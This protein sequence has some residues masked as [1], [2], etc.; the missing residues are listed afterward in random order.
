MS[1]LKSGD[2]PY[3][4]GYST[5]KPLALTSYS[6]LKLS[7]LTNMLKDLGLPTSVLPSATTLPA[8]LSILKTRHQQFVTLHNANTDIAP[9]DPLH[10][11]KK[12]LQA[13]LV[14][15]EKLHNAG[16]KT[17]DAGGGVATGGM[18][19]VGGGKQYMVCLG[20]PDHCRR[21]LSTSDPRSVPQKKHKID[22][23][24]LTRQARASMGSKVQRSNGDPPA[25]DSATPASAIASAS[26]RFKTPSPRS[27]VTKSSPKSAASLSPTPNQALLDPQYAV[28]TSA[29][30]NDREVDE[31]DDD[32]LVRLNLHPIRSSPSNEDEDASI[33]ERNLLKTARKRSMSPFDPSGPRPSQRVRGEEVDLGMESDA[34]MEADMEGEE[35]DAGHKD[36]AMAEK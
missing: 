20:A 26:V 3:T 21:L 23:E 15:W 25:S 6:N 5:T 17:S 22:F 29:V 12:E 30:T 28:P 24:E 9:E 27:P 10:K 16:D 14:K 4:N 2:K 11:S 31:E 7:T 18:A 1:S 34:D 35:S 32:E 8:Q 36:V 19:A 33:V 13:E